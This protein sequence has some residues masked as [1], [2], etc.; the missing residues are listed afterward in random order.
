MLLLASKSGERGDPRA[1]LSAATAKDGDRAPFQALSV[2]GFEMQVSAPAQSPR[3][4]LPPQQPQL[5]F[6]RCCYC[7]RRACH[8]RRKYL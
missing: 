3:P 7:R 5:Q 2:F 4:P 6:R 1:V 8:R